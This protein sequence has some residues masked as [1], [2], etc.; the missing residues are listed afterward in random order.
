MNIVLG[1]KPT[2]QELM[3]LT[4][5]RQPEHAALVELLKAR[6]EE[7][8]TSLVSTENLDQLRRNQ[9]AARWA[10]DFLEAIEKSPEVLER[11]K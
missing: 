3:A 4:R 9:G 1:H 10:Q 8:K 2:R 6:L 5:L 11:L 7:V